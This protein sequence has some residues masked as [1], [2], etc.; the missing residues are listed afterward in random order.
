MQLIHG[1]SVA[2]MRPHAS[3]DELGEPAWG[4]PEREEVENVV[5]KPGASDDM[6]ASR[7]NGVEVSYTLS[8]PKTYGKSLRGCS[9]EVRGEAFDVVGDPKPLTEANTPG[10]WNLTV[11][12]TRTD[13]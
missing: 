10:A 9:I 3:Y 4:E 8:F 6:G 12:V 2:V 11:E 1:E 5:V 7:P 13:G